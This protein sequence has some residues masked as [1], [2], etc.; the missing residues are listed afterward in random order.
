MLANSFAVFALSLLLEVF[1]PAPA[2]FL[3][4]SLPEPGWQGEQPRFD[5]GMLATEHFD[6]R[7]APE[8]AGSW[9]E[10]AAVLESS[11][12]AF[13]QIFSIMGFEVT[14]PPEALGWHCFNQRADYERYCERTACALA[15]LDSHYS[16]RSNQVILFQQPLQEGQRRD[17]RQITHEAAHQMAFNCG[18]M[19]RG[20]FYPFWLA[21]G[22][23]TNFERDEDGPAFRLP[24]NAMRRDGL[25]QR[26]MEGGLLELADFITVTAITPD[27]RASASELYDESW[28]LFRF[29]LLRHPVELRRYMARLRNH[30]PATGDEL[31][32]LDGFCELFGDLAPLEREWHDFAVAL[33][34]GA[35]DQPFAAGPALGQGAQRRAAGH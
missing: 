21:E 10:L 20:V 25:T 29:L 22:L 23:A 16:T 32:L 4:Y 13:L 9:V 18:L 1:A 7:Y 34:H 28:G 26:V 30:P 27:L 2:P 6:I 3:P 11:Y 24:E 12:R 14:D 19:R 17:Y 35:P 31:A 15:W 5:P 8:E 33:A